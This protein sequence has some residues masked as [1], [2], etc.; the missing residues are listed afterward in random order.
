MKIHTRLLSSLLILS[1]LCG[2]ISFLPVCEGAVARSKKSQIS[3]EDS[4]SIPQV[5]LDYKVS[6]EKDSTEIHKPVVLSK[7]SK[8]GQ[9]VITAT[10]NQLSKSPAT[11]FKLKTDPQVIKQRWNM[12]LNNYGEPMP[13]QK[14]AVKYTAKL[15]APTKAKR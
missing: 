13:G 10:K 4:D 5:P 15:K 1:L 14:P 9:A 3:K 6:D 11:K 8:Y 7:A 2:A 12:L